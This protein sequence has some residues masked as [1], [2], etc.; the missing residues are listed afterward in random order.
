MEMIWTSTRAT[1]PQTN[2]G[3][4]MVPYMGLHVRLGQGNW[5]W[6]SG[7]GSFPKSADPDADPNILESLF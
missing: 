6:G 2:T 7:F 3:P 4:E 5:L 1:L